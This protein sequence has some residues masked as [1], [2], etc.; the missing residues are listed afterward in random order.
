M[1][2]AKACYRSEASTY[3]KAKACNR[4]LVR[5]VVLASIQENE[6]F[7]VDLV[8]V[9][10]RTEGTFERLSV[11]LGNVLC[12]FHPNGFPRHS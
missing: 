12:I 2:N 6:D 9:G 7:L 10:R 8:V 11:G 3:R 5:V 4:S 1:Q